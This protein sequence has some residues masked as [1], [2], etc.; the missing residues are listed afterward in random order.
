VV[1]FTASGLSIHL[2][3]YARNSILSFPEPPVTTWFLCPGC[4][5]FHPQHLHPFAHSSIRLLVVASVQA[6]NFSRALRELVGAR[7]RAALHV[8][9]A[10]LHRRWLLL[11]LFGAPRAVCESAPRFT[12]WE[13]RRGGPP[14]SQVRRVAIITLLLLLF[15]LLFVPNFEVKKR[16]RF[17]LLYSRTF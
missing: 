15:V 4:F 6:C 7:Q 8:R 11:A 3:C 16:A 9:L 1:A 14:L 17:T 12:G 10:L 2:R 5:S 13:I